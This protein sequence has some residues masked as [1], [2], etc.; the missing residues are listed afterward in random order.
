MP[1]LEGVIDGGRSI[2]RHTVGNVNA[3]VKDVS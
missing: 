3:P 2:S 1:I